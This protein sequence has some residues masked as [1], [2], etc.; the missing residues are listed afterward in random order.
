[1]H[2]ICFTKHTG[3]KLKFPRNTAIIM[4]PSNVA[5]HDCAECR[6]V[7]VRTCNKHFSV[8]NTVAY[9]TTF[10]FVTCCVT[11][12]HA[13]VEDENYLILSAN[14]ITSIHARILSGKKKKR[15]LE[16]RL[17]RPCHQHRLCFASYGKYGEGTCF[18]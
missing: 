1:M 5:V 11:P 12:P 13:L 9:K 2:K 17:T 8:L 18:L 15:N 16:A 14:V 10:I 7:V 4:A 6:V 3:R